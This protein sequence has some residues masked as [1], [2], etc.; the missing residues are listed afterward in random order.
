MASKKGANQ[1]AANNRLRNIYEDIM[2]WIEERNE[3]KSPKLHAQPHTCNGSQPARAASATASK[4]QAAATRSS[5][6]MPSAPSQPPR[7]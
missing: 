5:S 4:V 7:S 3:G 2:L 1:R 6:M